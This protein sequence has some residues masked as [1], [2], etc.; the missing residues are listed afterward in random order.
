[1]DDQ[2]V[3]LPDT[4]AELT[5]GVQVR[6]GSVVEH[7]PREHSGRA[8]DAR[9]AQVLVPRLALRVRAPRADQCGDGDQ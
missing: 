1:M 2:S 5:A 3:K 9:C 4:S 8:V 7:R 6:S